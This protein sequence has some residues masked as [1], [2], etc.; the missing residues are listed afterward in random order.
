[1]TIAEVTPRAIAWLG[2]ALR[3]EFGAT[4]LLDA[5]SR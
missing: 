4:Q 1:V 3:R 5:I 2:R